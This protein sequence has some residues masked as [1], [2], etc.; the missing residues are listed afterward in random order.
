VVGDEF[1]Q[2]DAAPLFHY[3]LRYGHLRQ[4]GLGVIFRSIEADLDILA[5]QL[6]RLRS[7]QQSG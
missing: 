6:A 4:P 1:E 3:E 2:V 5:G 7:A